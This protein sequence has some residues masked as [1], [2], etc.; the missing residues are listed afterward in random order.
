MCPGLLAFAF[1]TEAWGQPLSSLLIC[2]SIVSLWFESQVMQPARTHR[3]EKSEQ[4]GSEWAVETPAIPGVRS[5]VTG[6]RP[7]QPWFLG[8]S[9]YWQLSPGYF[10]YPS[11]FRLVL[12]E[13]VCGLRGAERRKCRGRWKCVDLVKGE[14]GESWCHVDAPSRPSP[15]VCV[16]PSLAVSSFPVCIPLPLCPPSPSAC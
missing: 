12:W 15:S 13:E 10:L 7:W 5:V 8:L 6:C 4:V 16:P 3:S 1:V 9:R 2:W 14:Q 11:Q